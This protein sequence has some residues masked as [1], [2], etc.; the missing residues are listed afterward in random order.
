MNNPQKNP[1]TVSRRDFLKTGIGAGFY[2]LIIKPFR[3]RFS[4]FEATITSPRN[5]PETT[6]PEPEFEILPADYQIGPDQLVASKTEYLELISNYFRDQLIDAKVQLCT[7]LM[8]EVQLFSANARQNIAKI[9]PARHFQA[10]LTLP[11]LHPTQLEQVTHPDLLSALHFLFDN[12]RTFTQLVNATFG[13]SKAFDSIESNQSGRRLAFSINKTGNYPFVLDGL[14]P[15]DFDYQYR[16]PLHRYEPSDQVEN[17]E[18]LPQIAEIFQRAGEM[19]GIPPAV[20]EAIVV[21]ETGGNPEQPGLVLS[22]TAQSEYI[23]H[24]FDNPHIHLV[25]SSGELG[26]TQILPRTI[27][28]FHNADQVVWGDESSNNIHNLKTAVAIAAAKIYV[29]TLALKDVEQYRYTSQYE[30]KRKDKISE[31]YGEVTQGQ[32]RAHS[33][34]GLQTLLAQRGKLT[35][36]DIDFISLATIYYHGSNRPYTR[37]GGRSYDEFVRAYY[38]GSL[39]QQNTTVQSISARVSIEE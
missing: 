2:Q 4:F 9:M 3:D 37:L 38:Q 22:T 8:N 27:D 19:F 23:Q 39:Q 34:A 12:P 33:A 10:L 32:E 16:E 13:F 18:L 21:I 6:T 31:L 1:D 29:D 7:Q 11:H 24:E 20:L 5:T 28:W 17:F 14:V 25:G 36:D 26:P 30:D 15:N 35:H